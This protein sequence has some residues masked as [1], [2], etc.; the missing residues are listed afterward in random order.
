MEIVILGNG[1]LGSEIRKQ[2]DWDMVCRQ[3]DNFDITEPETYHRYLKYY[4]TVLN[5]IGF[6]DTYSLDMKKHWNV[7]YAG[8]AYLTDYCNFY[9]KKLIHISTDY[10]YSNSVENSYEEDVPAHCN[11]WYGYTKLLGDGYIQLRLPADKYLI[12]RT[13]FKPNPFPYDKAFENL[14]GNFD[15]VDTISELIVQLIRKGASGIYN[16]GT[17]SK[18]M[19]DLAIKTVPYVGKMTGK[20]H[21]T[22]PEN[23][24]M[25]VS[26]MNNF[27]E[28]N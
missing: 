15:Y 11:N 21:H 27:L 16:V 1:L 7:N 2:T 18:S 10:L 23:V 4:D 13:S 12:I 8:V 25:D 28:E 5:C 20:T 3:R 26:K 9:K 6:T 22:M 19:Y 14:R 17:D 24:T